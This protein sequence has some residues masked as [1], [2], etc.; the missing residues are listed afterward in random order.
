M[1]G[2]ESIKTSNWQKLKEQ[3]PLRASEL[4]SEIVDYENMNDTEK[5]AS[6]RK[7]L[8]Y[9]SKDNANRFVYEDIAVRLSILIEKD[10]YKRRISDL[11]G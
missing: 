9:L 4:I 11:L 2:L 1:E 3:A 10:R 5:I 6:L 7:L 8:N